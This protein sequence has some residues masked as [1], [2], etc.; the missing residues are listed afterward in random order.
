M[1]TK[2]KYTSKDTS[3]PPPVVDLDHQQL[4]DH[5]YQISEINYEFYLHEIHNWLHQKHLDSSDE[6]G[7]WNSTLPQYI[8][9]QVPY[10]LE[11]FTSCQSRYMPSERVVFSHNVENLFYIND[12]AISECSKSRMTPS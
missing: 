1:A 8:F 10:F 5:L 4:I 2:G 3:I 11:F 12:N 6:I 9:P 7:L